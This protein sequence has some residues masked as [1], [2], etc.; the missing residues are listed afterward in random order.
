MQYIATLTLLLIS[1]LAGAQKQNNN[2][3]FGNKAGLDFN[4]GT[5]VAFTSAINC[6]EGSATVSDRKTGAL[7]FYTDG[8]RIWNKNH[9]IM[10]N[11][12]NIGNDILSSSLQG[13]LI[14]PF[15]NDSNKYYVFALE[16]ESASEGAL[17]YSVVD[18]QLDAGLGDVMLNRKKVKLGKGFVEGMQAVPTCDGHWLLLSSRTANEFHAYK[19]TASGIDTQAVVSVMPY[20]YIT[21]VLGAMKISPDRRKLLYATYTSRQVGGVNYAVATIH[22]FDERT[23]VV[24][25]GQ[26]LID[27]TPNA[28]Y[29]SVEFSEDGSKAYVSDIRYGIYQFDLSLPTPLDIKASKKTVYQ[30]IPGRSA[31]LMQMGP[32]KNIYVAIYGM[33][34]VDRIGNTNAAV[35]AVTYTT[36]AVALAPGTTSLKSFPPEVTYPEAGSLDI[37]TSAKTENICVGGSTILE[38][39]QGALSY[40]WQ[41][42][43]AQF[44]LTA[45]QAGTYWVNSQFLC[46]EQIDT[47]YIGVI[48]QSVDLGPDTTICIGRP[49][50]VRPGANVDSPAYTWQDGSTADSL[51]IERAGTYWVMA[52]LGQCIAYDTIRVAVNDSAFFSLGADTILCLEQTYDLYLPEDVKKY[53]WSTGEKDSM[54][55]V[56]QPNKYYLEIER[57]GCSYTDTIEILY[58]ERPQLGNDTVL[59]NGDEYVL[60]AKSVL[61]SYYTWNTGAMSDSIVV[62]TADIYTVTVE[63]RCG[64]LKDTIQVDYKVCDCDP[65]IPTAFTPNNDGR[66]D[67]FGPL[68]KCRVESYEFIVVNRFGEAV[69]RST[70]KQEKW[71]GTYKGMPCDV[72]G[73]FYL[74]R[75]KNISGKDD[76]RKGDVILIR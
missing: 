30:N 43:S 20:P 46:W 69:F 62:S 58:A 74:L 25:N 13:M 32:D 39:R 41:N 40:L 10:P 38:G 48:N 52:D 6:D 65:F 22:D 50:V 67:K 60:N 16:H 70:D 53:T 15:T 19:I 18:M 8:V 37:Y 23:G 3:C 51:L 57:G 44:N 9:T 21:S 35:P 66:N 45:R 12:S 34:Y 56:A 28:T 7:L 33:N 1:F 73:Y 5:P 55:T 29:Y 47:F 61:N 27:P 71:D 31:T 63:N 4:A 49:L 59:C 2:W 64:V 68:M 75:L 14:V 11:G 36:G 72:G 42:N 76:S 24:S 54:I 26:H 17:F